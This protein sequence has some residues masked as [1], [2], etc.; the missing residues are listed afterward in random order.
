MKKSD[1]IE[2][3]FI[4]VISD[5]IVK[6]EHVLLSIE[7]IGDVVVAYV[8]S[9]LHSGFCI[10]DPQG[11]FLYFNAENPFEAIK[12]GEKITGYDPNF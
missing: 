2:A 7:D 3:G 6:Y 8:Y 5:P 9:D 4:P 10:V 12:W 11:I 1:F